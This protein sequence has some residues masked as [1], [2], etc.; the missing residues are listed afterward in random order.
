[1]QACHDDDA[2]RPT[3]RSGD[4]TP[5][6]ARRA[7][8]DLAGFEAGNGRRPWLLAVVLPAWSLALLINAAPAGPV[9]A[10]SRR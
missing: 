9:R 3:R 5:I 7:V 4:A 6:D 8:G 10:V 1:M 2:R